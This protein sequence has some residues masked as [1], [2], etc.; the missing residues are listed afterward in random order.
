MRKALHNA[1]CLL[2]ERVQGRPSPLQRTGHS[3]VAVLPFNVLTPRRTYSVLS[4]VQLP[5]VHW[6]SRHIRARTQQTG[7]DLANEPLSHNGRHFPHA[8]RPHQRLPRG[9]QSSL[10]VQLLQ[11]TQRYHQ[12]RESPPRF[13]VVSSRGGITSQSS[14]PLTLPKSTYPLVLNTISPSVRPSC[15]L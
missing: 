4:L 8:R 11:I 10:L 13:R 9:R 15:H 2:I 14:G 1:F 6:L 12:R 5:F 3:L 7:R